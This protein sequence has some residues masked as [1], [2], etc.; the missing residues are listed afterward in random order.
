MPLCLHITVNSAPLM[1]VVLQ[2]FEMLT[3]K[4][5]PVIMKLDCYTQIKYA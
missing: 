4:P 5:P 1:L 2:T 3:V